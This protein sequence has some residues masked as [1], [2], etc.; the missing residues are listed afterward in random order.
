MAALC[1]SVACIALGGNC[2]SSTFLVVIFVI[3]RL[4]YES[5]CL[6]SQIYWK[7]NVF[8]VSFT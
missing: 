8:F 2:V 7:N 3:G 1:N 4:I 6:R 5:I